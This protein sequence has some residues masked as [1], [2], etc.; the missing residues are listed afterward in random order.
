[1]ILSLFGFRRRGA[2]KAE[3]LAGLS[4]PKSDRAGLVILRELPD[5][6][7]SSLL[8]EIEKAPDSVPS[9]SGVSPE[10]AH[11]AKEAL[12][13]M[14]AIRAY[15]DVPLEEFVSDVCD[16]LREHGELNTS[17]EIRFRE[18]LSRLLDIEALAVAAKAV[19]LRQEHERNFCTVRILTDARPVYGNG[20]SGP[21]SAMIITH[22][23][24]L[25]YHEGAGGHVSDIYLSLGSDDISELHNALARAETKAK[26]LREVFERAKL[27]F[28][29]PHQE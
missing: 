17:D 22:T 19:L 15:H 12:D 14:Y 7:F 13:T 25:S 2:F 23:M 27:K 20:V 11:Q 4:I 16:S 21:P 6:V 9:L 3:I 29:D 8:I 10:E 26:S 28:I 5:G 18:R 24:K 1:V